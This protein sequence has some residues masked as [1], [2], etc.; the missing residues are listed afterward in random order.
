MIRYLFPALYAYFNNGLVKA[1][2]STIFEK[3]TH[4]LHVGKPQ[5]QV[6]LVV[7]FRHVNGNTGKFYTHKDVTLRHCQ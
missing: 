3:L 7:T 1:I 4:P 6:K 2:C 5:A